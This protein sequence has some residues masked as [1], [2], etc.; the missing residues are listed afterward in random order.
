V[1]ETHADGRGIP[2]CKPPQPLDFIDVSS[3]THQ[4]PAQRNV[5]LR[6]MA[7]AGVSNSALQCSVTILALDLGIIFFAGSVIPD[8]YVA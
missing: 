7:L 2:L 6:A 5:K 1:D 3:R 4:D 8:A